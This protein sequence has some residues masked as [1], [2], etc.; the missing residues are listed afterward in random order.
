MLKIKT[1]IFTICIL[2][3]F[4]T[5]CFAGGGERTK[6]DL[7]YAAEN[8][9]TPSATTNKTTDSK[10]SSADRQDKKPLWQT[11]ST[12]F[13]KHNVTTA[14]Q[15]ATDCNTNTVL[16]KLN[17][18]SAQLNTTYTQCEPKDK[19]SCKPGFCYVPPDTSHA[20]CDKCKDG[21]ECTPSP[22][23][24]K[25]ATKYFWDSTTSSCL[26]KECIDDYVTDIAHKKCVTGKK[27]LK[28]LNQLDKDYVKDFEQLLDA[29]DKV[30]KKYIENCLKDGGTI[31]EWE[32]HE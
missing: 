25:R 19:T 29:Y 21:D 15:N 5:T 20:R 23:L 12:L 7:D 24:D 2:A 9:D 4:T 31:E 17:A 14:L 18:T 22:P 13:Q 8:V 10:Q 30:A 27:Q 32:C 28:E 26:I 6:Y 1:N 16:N 3:L 11:T